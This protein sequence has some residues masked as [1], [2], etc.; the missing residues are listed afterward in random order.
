LEENAYK[1]IM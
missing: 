1:L